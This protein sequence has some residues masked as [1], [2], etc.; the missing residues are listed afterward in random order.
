MKSSVNSSQ[1]IGLQNDHQID[2]WEKAYLRFET[3]EEEI[4]KFTRR[5]QDLRVTNWPKNLRIVELFCGR[6]NGLKAWQ[7]LGFQDIEGVDQSSRLIGEYSGSAKCYIADCRC[8][9]FSPSSKDV[10]VIQGGL[11]HLPSLPDDLD[12][13]CAE[14]RRVLT[15]EGYVLFVEPWLTP[16]LRFVH[17]VMRSKM[18]RHVSPKLDALAT[19]VEYEQHTYMQWLSQPE[20]IR[21]VALKY[22]IPLYESFAWG[23]WHF[24]GKPRS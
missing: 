7:Q 4:R 11:H 1:A 5:L 14:I 21:M 2:P 23:K 15:H 16:F 24:L 18:A 19:M 22:F 13:T 3:E 10:A 12:R 9:P 6:G 17:V 20:T 8:L